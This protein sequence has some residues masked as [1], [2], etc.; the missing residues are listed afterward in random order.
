MKENLIKYL[1]EKQT[2]FTLGE[3]N[4]IINVISKLEEP[5]EKPVEA[6]K[7]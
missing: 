5:K 4:Q 6:K 1:Q 2:T 3:L 7:K